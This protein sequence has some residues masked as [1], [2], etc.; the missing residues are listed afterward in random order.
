MC[1]W[2][3]LCAELRAPP[4]FQRCGYGEDYSLFLQFG[5]P[6]VVDWLE[7]GVFVDRNGTG[8][9]YFVCTISVYFVG[10]IF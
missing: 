6:A 4:L 5:D 10:I 3:A 7:T 8:I 2:D 9:L 1:H